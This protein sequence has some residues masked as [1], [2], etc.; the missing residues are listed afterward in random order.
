M[1]LNHFYK[2]KEPDPTLLGRKVSKQSG[3]PF[4]SGE[5]TATISGY[6]FNDMTKKLAFTFEEDDSNVECFR[7]TLID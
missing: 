4:K 5:K 3:R 6:T 7:C 2:A 1:N